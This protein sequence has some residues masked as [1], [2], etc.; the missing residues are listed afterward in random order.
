MQK[1]NVYRLVSL[2]LL[3]NII[4]L[5][6]KQEGLTIVN[7][8][9][10]KVRVKYRLKGS[11]S[12]VNKLLSPGKRFSFVLG[13]ATIF[14]YNRKYTVVIPRSHPDRLLKLTEIIKAAKQQRTAHGGKGKIGNIEVF[15][16]SIR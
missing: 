9:N 15:F 8:T 12:T 3:I 14:Y 5:K 13:S 2:S 16:Q 11:S 7:D 10:V 4:P 6:A 1:K